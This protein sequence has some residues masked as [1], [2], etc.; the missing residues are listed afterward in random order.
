LSRQRVYGWLLILVGLSI[1]VVTLALTALSASALH[2]ASG[3]TSGLVLSALGAL[4]VRGAPAEPTLAASWRAM[5]RQLTALHVLLVVAMLEVAINRIAVP[6]LRPEHAPPPS[7][8]IALD[9]VALFLSYFT[10]TLAAFVIVTRAIAG[11][12]AERSPRESAALAAL[13][14]AA[15]LCAIPLVVATPVSV[16]LVLEVV[17]AVALVGMAQAI[18][19][20]GADLGIRIGLPLVMIP[21]LLHSARGFGAR[22]MWNDIAFDSPGTEL[23][24][25]GMWALC[26]VALVTP[27]CFAPRP[28]ARA[29]TRPLPIV[30]AMVVAGIGATISRISYPAAAKVASLA[31]GVEMTSTKP[32]PR[33]AVYLLAIATLAWTLTS[34]ATAASEA[35]RSVGAGLTLIV[36]G[37]YAFKWPHHYLLPLLGVALIADAA[38]R[39]RDEELAAL[40][41]VAEAPPVADTTWSAYVGH[42]V[43]GLKRALTDVHSLT[44]R[45]DGGLASSLI[46]GEAR[47]L[48]V[49]TR[50]E[51]IDGSVLALDVVIGREIDELRGATLAVW[52]IPERGQGPNPA[53]PPATPQFRTGD[54]SFDVRFKTRGSSLAFA[55]LFDDGLRARAVATLDGW[56]AYWEREGL[57]YRI[58]P[59]RGAPLDHPMP[60]S[61]LALGK[62]PPNAERLVAVIELLVEIA[63]R[64]IEAAQAPPEPAELAS[65]EVE[66]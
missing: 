46:V 55:Q 8:H 28:F 60:L 42:I 19:V 9:Y 2:T 24:R 32:D 48:S 66:S 14:I 50:I 62:A 22:L 5:R 47:G 44:T 4:R 61:D 64:G 63:S 40:P 36:L 11:M 31:V 54:A 18:Q 1:V 59:G 58:Y 49:R 43:A 23:A 33:L 3:L 34:C 30:V 41:L 20:R 10:G 45:G 17:F 26:L 25:L 57:R 16:T 39:V 35:R 12:R 15:V 29:V 27:Y 6:L 56:L 65:T 37:G 53:S 13:G 51:R 7:W 21:L 38:R 52:A